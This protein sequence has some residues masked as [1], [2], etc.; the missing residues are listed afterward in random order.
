MN[1]GL[2]EEIDALRE[3]VARFAQDKLAP[4]AAEIDRDNDIPR[5]LWRRWASLAC[6]A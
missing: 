2:G 1:F 4:L 3:T 5:D 6:S